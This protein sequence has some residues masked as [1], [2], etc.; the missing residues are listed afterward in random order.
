MKRIVN[1]L[2]VILSILL[3]LVT[4][5]FSALA[6]IVEPAQKEEPSQSL[7]GTEPLKDL[8]LWGSVFEE[9]VSSD[10]ETAESV[11]VGASKGDAVGK[12]YE[13]FL[14]PYGAKYGYNGIYVKN[15]TGLSL[16]LQTE[17]Q[18]KIAVTL[19]NTAEP[20]V[21]IVHTHATECYMPEERDFYTA[22]DKFR[23]TNNDKNVTE[24]GEIIAEKLREGGIGVIH[25][26]TQHD[27]PAY[28]GSYSRSAETIKEY[29][30][31]YPSIKIVVDVHRDSIAMT[32]NDRCKPTV[33]INGKKAAQVMLVMGSQTGSVSGYP[34]WRKNFRFALGFQQTMEAKYPGLARPAVLCSARYNQELTTGSILL[35]V[36]TD[37]NTFEEAC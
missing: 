15:N 12:I 4:F 9:S 33:S 14:S 27:Y 6:Y 18:S 37:S 29:L 31:Q 13:Q 2:P 16:N 36:G 10:R 34:Q 26:R 11:T 25:D 3:S 20:Q 28:T 17:L 32:D 22:A 30:K 23:T 1:A 8:S 19:K 35:E 21:L 24:I 5:S 7:G